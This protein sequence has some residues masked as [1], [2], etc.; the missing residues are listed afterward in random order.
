MSSSFPADL[1][2]C[3][4][5][6]SREHTIFGVKGRWHISRAQMSCL[7][8]RTRV[9]SGMADGCS[10]GIVACPMVDI[11]HAWCVLVGQAGGGMLTCGIGLGAGE[12]GVRLGGIEWEDR[13][14]SHH[15]SR[16]GPLLWEG[17][18]LGHPFVILLTSC[19][20]FV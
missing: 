7:C 14:R 4:T 9:A 20:Y 10:G 1:P 6:I 19:G 2:S 15:L 12:L 13:P 18:W 3:C 17:I 5:R 16:V 11:P 8:D